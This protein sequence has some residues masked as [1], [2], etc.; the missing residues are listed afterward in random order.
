VDAGHILGSASVILECTEGSRT[1][2]LI[3]SGDI[4]RWGQP[5]I[6]DPQPP[7]GGDVV[8]MESTYGDRDHPKLADMRDKLASI[9]SETAARGG[10]VII[11]AFAVG[12]TQEMIY[13]LHG[14]MQERRIP[15]I[16]IYIDSPLASQATEV[17]AK[18]PEV[19]DTD[20]QMVRAVKD[21]FQFEQLHYTTDVAE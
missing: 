11:P 8:I 12:R 3:F 15:S 5:I 18:H 10:R 16:P 14:L 17:F 21:L 20:E 19:Y 13:D 9:V 1:R 7:G 4:G 2:R 6:R